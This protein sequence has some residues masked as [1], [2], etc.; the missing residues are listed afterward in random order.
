MPYMPS[1]N[2]NRKT[3]LFSITYSVCNKNK[4]GKNAILTNHI[5][6]T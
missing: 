5:V 6:K 1:F 3:T 2:A 4:S